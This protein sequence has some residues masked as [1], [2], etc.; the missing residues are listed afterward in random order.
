MVPMTGQLCCSAGVAVFGHSRPDPA[1]QAQAEAVG[2]VLAAGGYTVVN[3]GYGGTMAASAKGAR[4]AGGDVIGVT[5]RAWKSS[6]NPFLTRRVD[7]EDLQ[8]R[9][10]TLIELAGAGFVVLPGGTGT[11]VELATAWELMNKGLAVDRPLVC[12]GAFWRPAF[13]LVARAQPEAAG[14]VQ[15]VDDVE[16]LNRVF[17]PLRSETAGREPQVSM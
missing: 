16:G 7:T 4:A 3:G 2:A 8:Q 12:L 10:A 14:R 5:C 15:F 9:V 6:P 1:G 13:E 11:L 17:P